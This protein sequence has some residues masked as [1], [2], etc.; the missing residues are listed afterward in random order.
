[1]NL[2]RFVVATG[3]IGGF[4]WLNWRVV[5]PM[6]LFRMEL[7]DPSLPANGYV[8]VLFRDGKSISA[9]TLNMLKIGWSTIWHVWYFVM[10]GLLFGLMIGYPLGE[11]AR[12]KFAIAQASDEAI[13]LGE[14]LFMATQERE[15][16]AENTLKK[17][18]VFN[19]ETRS[20]QKKIS[21]EKQEIF[22]MKVTAETELE[23]AQGFRQ[24]NASLRKEINKARAKIRRLEK[25]R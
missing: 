14:E 5:P 10:A 15:V 22:E 18:Q 19:A 16:I 9:T 1:M 25:H 4:V 3:I 24:R 17:V 20:M 7:F 11:L 6:G 2:V 21:Q 12:R 8:L 13:R 23:A